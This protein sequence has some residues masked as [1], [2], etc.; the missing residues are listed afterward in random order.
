MEQKVIIVSTKNGKSI[1][2]IIDGL[3]YISNKTPKS[4]P[5]GIAKRI[6]LRFPSFGFVTKKVGA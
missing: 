6:I 1:T 5:L 3:P 4:F 2:D